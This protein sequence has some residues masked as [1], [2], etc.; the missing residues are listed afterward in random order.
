MAAVLDWPEY[1]AQ[2]R[3]EPTLLIWVNRNCLPVSEMVTTRMRDAVPITMPKAVMVARTLSARKDWVAK[4][5]MS[6]KTIRRCLLG[7]AKAALLTV[8]RGMFLSL[9]R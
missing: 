8:P 9:F 7:I 3:L 2:I 4:P 5:Q 6:R 1:S